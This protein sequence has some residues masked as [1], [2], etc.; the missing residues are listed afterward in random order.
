MFHDTFGIYA[1][2]VGPTTAVLPD[3]W[4]DRLIRY[5][6]PRS[7]MIA[8]CLELHDLWIAKAIA[9]R[10]KDREFC[11]ALLVAGLVDSVTLDSRLSGVPRASSVDLDR[12]QAWITQPSGS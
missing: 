3:G 7:G 2:G 1:Q 4:R 9:G 11:D 8:W 12:A 6:E 5:E 10:P